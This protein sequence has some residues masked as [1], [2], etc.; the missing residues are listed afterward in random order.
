MALLTD[1]VDPHVHVRGLDKAKDVLKYT[2]AYCAYTLLMPNVPPLIDGQKT[3]AYNDGAAD[4]IKGFGH[5]CGLIP[6]MMLD[7]STTPE[8]ISE[9]YALGVRAAK[10]Y[11]KGATTRD[12]SVAHVYGV[13][14]IEK[15]VPTFAQMSEVGMTLNLHGEMPNAF[16]LDREAAFLWR[17]EFLNET[18]PDLKMVLEHITTQKSVR[19][20]ENLNKNVAGSITAQHLLDNLDIVLGD[21]VNVH[22]YCKPVHKRPEDQKALKDAVFSKNP[23]FFFGSDSAPHAKETKECAFGCAGAFT[24][25][26]AIELVLTALA[27]EDELWRVVESAK[28]FL[29]HNARKFY[30]LKA[31]GKVVEITDK[32]Y[33]V[34]TEYTFGDSV[35]VPYRAGEE[36]PFSVASH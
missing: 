2:S 4:L 19:L 16:V 29:S 9:A 21:K 5:A 7:D 1:V 10:L 3:K 20:I 28:P 31:T 27:G 23:K 18:L 15:M 36:L 24:A 25:P 30:G 8:M 12:E 35:V 6:C 32:P 33:K 34:P 14:A 26:H 13:S 11:P 22:A 17:V